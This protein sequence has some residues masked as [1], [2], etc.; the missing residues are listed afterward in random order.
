MLMFYTVIETMVDST[1]DKTSMNE[2]RE[3]SPQAS[4]DK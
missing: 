1:I 3:P 4:I 2:Q